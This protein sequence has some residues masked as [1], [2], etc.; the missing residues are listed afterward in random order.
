MI[1]NLQFV[2]AGANLHI[3]LLIHKNKMIH[4]IIFDFGGVIYDIDHHLSKLAFEKLGVKDFDHLFGHEIQTEVFEKLEKGQLNKRDFLDYLSDFV[5]SGTSDKQIEDAWCALLI[6]YDNKILDLLKSLAKNYRIF[7][8]SNTNI[9]HYE[10]FISEL[11]KPEDLRSLFDDVWFSHEKG[12]RK[13][14]AE[15]YTALMDQNNLIPEET[16]YIDDLE[17]NIIAANKLGVNGYY[18]KNESILDLFE[19][20]I[21]KGNQ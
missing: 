15:I 5:A 11:D 20:A 2:I 18:L 14:D 3:C 6:G 17:T 12:M 8:L 9:L 1:L 10:A 7:L 4:N 13:P 16:L 19:N 21:W